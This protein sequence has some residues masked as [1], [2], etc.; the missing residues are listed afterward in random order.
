[1]ETDE[2]ESLSDSYETTDAQQQQ[3]QNIDFVLGTDQVEDLAEIFQ[4]CTVYFHEFKDFDTLKKL[5]RYVIAYDGDVD[6]TMTS[7]TTHVVLENG[8]G[9]AEDERLISDNIPVV[10][11][12]WILSCVEKGCLL[13]TRE[14]A[15]S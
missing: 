14:F 8:R 9:L 5:S 1:M 7:S 3:Q 11:E 6:K 12:R 2:E 13:D 4:G 15:C 10:G